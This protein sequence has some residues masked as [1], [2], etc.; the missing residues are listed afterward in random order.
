M[1]EENSFVLGVFGVVLVVS[2]VFTVVT[3][4]EIRDIKEK[5]RKLD[6]LVAILPAPGTTITDYENKER[7]DV[8]YLGIKIN[9]LEGK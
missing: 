3:G 8:W 7:K 2:L 6:R 9:A 5:M 4:C 1:S